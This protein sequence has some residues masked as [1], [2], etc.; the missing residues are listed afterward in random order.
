MKDA[1]W[2]LRGYGLVDF[3]GL[4]WWTMV[5]DYGGWTMDYWWTMVDFGSGLISGCEENIV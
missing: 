3:G 1:I 5:V 2:W 4:W